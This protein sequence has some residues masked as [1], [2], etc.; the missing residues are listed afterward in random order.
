[1][2]VLLSKESA[3]RRKTSLLCL[4]GY[5]AV[6]FWGFDIFIVVVV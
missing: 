3:D 5:L 6:L 4:L 2:Q 1:M